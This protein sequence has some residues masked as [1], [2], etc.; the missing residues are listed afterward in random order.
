M[1]SVSRLAFFYQFFT[2]FMTAHDPSKSELYQIIVFDI[3]QAKK[4]EFEFYD[5][6]KEVE[7]ALRSM[8]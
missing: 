4:M 5:L 8:C 1:H 3:Q 7:I 2:Q 6:K